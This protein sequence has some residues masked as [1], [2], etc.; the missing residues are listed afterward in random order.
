MPSRYLPPVLARYGVSAGLIKNA[1]SLVNEFL[2]RP[3]GLVW[4]PDAAGQPARMTGAAPSIFEKRHM[5]SHGGLLVRSFPVAKILE[6]EGHHDTKSARYFNTAYEEEVGMM[7]M[8]AQLGGTQKWLTVN[9][10]KCRI[11]HDGTTVWIDPSLFCANYTDVRIRYLAGWPEDKLPE[12]IQV[13]T[14]LL[15][16]WL[17]SDWLALL[18]R[19]ATNFRWTAGYQLQAFADTR[20]GNA[21]LLSIEKYKARNVG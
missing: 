4:V 15:A 6:A 7:G 21:A 11:S 14:A 1:S 12:D 18:R 5:P 8:A 13:A 2:D 3:E 16:K 19:F 9:P 10:A 17:D 20:E